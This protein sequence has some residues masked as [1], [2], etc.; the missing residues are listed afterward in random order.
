MKRVVLSVTNDLFTDPR[1]DKVA[2]SLERMGCAVLL[3]GRRYA[4]SPALPQRSYSTHRMRLLFRKGPAF[5]AEYQ[6]RL[7]LFLLFVRCDILVANDLDTL[8]PNV[9]VARLR[10]RPLFPESKSPTTDIRP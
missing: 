3:V 1:V 4:D 8:L 9:L 2:H 10:R 7:F 5:Y 6:F